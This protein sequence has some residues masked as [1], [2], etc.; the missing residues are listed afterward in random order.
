MKEEN[1]IKKHHEICLITREYYN[2]SSSI[3]YLKNVLSD[4][5]GIKSKKIELDSEEIEL[6]QGHLNNIVKG[7]ED[8]LK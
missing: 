4:L 7:I 5:Y 3:D 8:L 6:V 2:L 1:L